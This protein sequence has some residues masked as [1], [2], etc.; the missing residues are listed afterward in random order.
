[1]MWLAYRNKHGAIATAPRLEVQLAGVQAMIVQALGGK[2]E[3][4]DFMPGMAKTQDRSSGIDFEQ[5][6]GAFESMGLVS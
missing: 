5:A 2:A 4:R 3:P 6:L 1:M